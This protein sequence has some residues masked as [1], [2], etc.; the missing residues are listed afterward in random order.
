MNCSL[1]ELRAQCE[2]RVK[3]PEYIAKM[4]HRMPQT[5]VVDRVEFVLGRCLHQTVL[6]V[7]ASG[8]FHEQMLQV[9]AK[10]HGIDRADGLNIV[11]FDLDDVSQPALPV[12]PGITRVVCGEVLEHLSN[13]GWFLTRLHRQYGGIPT[14]ITVP[15]AFSSIASGHLRRGVENVNEDH[16]AWYSWKTMSV[17]LGRHGYTASEFYW[18]NGEPALAEGLVFVCASAVT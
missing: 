2:G 13:P 7:G 4:L 11:G 1:A 12:F 14:Y 3:T 8:P 6:H 15:N 10:V 18:Y 9:A 16:V 5:R 17:L